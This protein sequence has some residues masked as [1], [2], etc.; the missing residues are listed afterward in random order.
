[1]LASGTGALRP[2]QSS[3]KCIAHLSSKMLSEPGLSF[4]QGEDPLLLLPHPGAVLLKSKH[5]RGPSTLT[6]FV[7][8]KQTM[9]RLKQTLSVSTLAMWSRPL[10]LAIILAGVS[11]CTACRSEVR[12]PISPRY[13]RLSSS[14]PMPS[15]CGHN[16]RPSLTATISEKKL[17][18]QNAGRQTEQL[19]TAMLNLL[20][21]LSIS[22]AITLMPIQ[23]RSS[24]KAPT[25][26][27][28]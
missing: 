8:S 27:P 11:S 1:M 16:T 17:P 15:T 7:F 28:N 26:P 25:S 10:V 14:T 3:L 19:G 6:K 13:A 23:R 9:R 20:L 4:Q 2:C 21:L 24:S 12:S 18:V 22:R 5:E